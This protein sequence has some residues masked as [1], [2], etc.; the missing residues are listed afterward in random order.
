MEQMLHFLT[1]MTFIL[2]VFSN[3]I[4]FGFLTGVYTSKFAVLF[5]NKEVVKL[6]EPHIQKQDSLVQEFVGDSLV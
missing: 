1:F 2:A 6:I 5:L 4:L 3:T